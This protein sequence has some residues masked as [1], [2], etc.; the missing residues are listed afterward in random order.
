MYINI[1]VFTVLSLVNIHGH[2]RFGFNIFPA[3]LL[4]FAYNQ[5]RI[6][7]SPYVVKINMSTIPKLFQFV[8][9]NDFTGTTPTSIY[10]YPCTLQI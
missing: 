4:I 9:L 2:G 8:I 5:M 7:I 10:A 3:V 6:M 1:H